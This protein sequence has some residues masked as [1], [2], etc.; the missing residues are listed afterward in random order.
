MPRIDRADVRLL[1]A[2]VSEDG[3]VD[4]E[5]I[6]AQLLADLDEAIALLRDAGETHWSSWL[7]RDRERI[8]R[9]DPYGLDSLLRAF[10]GM[11]SFNDLVLAQPDAEPSRAG[12]LRQADNRLWDLRD[13]I[14][15]GCGQLGGN[16]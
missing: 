10:G 6:R 12:F 13:Q 7:E 15:H 16:P 5:R 4:V 3:H 1:A 9:G 8:G 11:G 2:E 14:W